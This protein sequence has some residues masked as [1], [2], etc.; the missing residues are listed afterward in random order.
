MKKLFLLIALFSS[1]AAFSQNASPSVT[2]MT[3]FPFQACRVHSSDSVQV[4]FILLSGNTVSTITVTQTAGPAAKFAVPTPTWS[5]NNAAVAFWLQGLAPGVYT[6]QAV[7]KDVAGNTTTVT[8]NVTVVADPVCP[9]CPTCPAIP[10]PRTV[11]TLQVNIL[12]TWVP[13]PVNS[14]TVKVVFTDGGNQ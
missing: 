4:Q 7:G 3:F 5:G 13:V 6:F 2:S 12:G 10:T 8:Q 11:A 9:V 1:L 14:S